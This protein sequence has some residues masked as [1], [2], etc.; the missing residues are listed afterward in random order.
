LRIGGQWT[1][2]P[3]K[4]PR[5]PPPASPSQQQP[6][7]P[8]GSRRLR[9]ANT[10]ASQRDFTIGAQHFDFDLPYDQQPPPPSVVD[11]R[12]FVSTQEAPKSDQQSLPE[13]VPTFQ[14]DVLPTPPTVTAS[15]S[16]PMS[17]SSRHSQH[18]TDS[19]HNNINTNAPNLTTSE[20]GDGGVIDVQG[21]DDSGAEI[22]SSSSSSSES[23]AAKGDGGG[24]TKINAEAKGGHKA[25]RRA[26]RRAEDSGS[27]SSGSESPAENGAVVV[28]LLSRKER[29]AASDTSTSKCICLAL[30]CTLYFF[31]CR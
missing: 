8:P 7:T 13:T 9:F 2:G 24:R 17:A 22:S 5:P 15:S 19:N 11:M 26:E 1:R 25:R 4:T 30:R 27:E 6:P 3:A 29:A 28:N 20:N 16:S 31:S 21:M 12:P 10:P 23:P 18:G 14:P